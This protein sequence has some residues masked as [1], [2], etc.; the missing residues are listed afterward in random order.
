MK[1]SKLSLL[2]IALSSFAFAQSQKFTMYEAVNGLRSNLAVKGIS[3]FSWTDDAKSYIQG[4]KNA[5]LITE[6][7]SMKMGTLVSLS[8]INK[9]L[10]AAEQL[11]SFPMVKFISRNKS[12]FTKEGKYYWREQSA[13]N[14]KISEWTALEKAAEN[15]TVL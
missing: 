11:K 5:Y 6:V 15:V 12:Y 3:Q 8:R 13:G 9:N 1:F 7:Q 14:S 2:L 10:S 4:S